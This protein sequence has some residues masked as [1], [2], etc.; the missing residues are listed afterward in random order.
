MNPRLRD[1]LVVAAALLATQVATA[2]QTRVVQGAPDALRRQIDRANPGDVL[3]VR[4]GTYLGAAVQI[5]LTLRRD[6]GVFVLP[7]TGGIPTLRLFVPAGQ[8]FA[9]TGGD[10]PGSGHLEPVFLGQSQ[11]DVIPADVRLGDGVHI[12]G[13]RAAF[14][15][16]ELG[17]SQVGGFLS[18]D[19]GPDVSVAECTMRNGCELVRGSLSMAF[20]SATGFSHPRFGGGLAFRVGIDARPALAASTPT[21]CVGPAGGL[22]LTLAS[23]PWA[24]PT[25]RPAASGFAP[26]AFAVSWVGLGPQHIPLSAI[27]PLTLPGCDQLTTT[28]ATAFVQTQGGVAA[29]GLSMPPPAAFAGLPFAHQFAQ[30]GLGAGGQVLSLSSSNALHLVVG[31]F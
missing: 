8:S 11:G 30:I 24:G 6:P 22:A 21:A 3:L 13:R 5:G 1:T 31:T 28:E 14:H 10:L 18:P 19:G 26:N 27:T 23:S 17:S 25:Y 4:A 20:G 7:K 9:M 12:E 2:Q 16:C 15:R 29:F